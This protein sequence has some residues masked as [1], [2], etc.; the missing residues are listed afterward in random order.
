MGLFVLFGGVIC[1]VNAVM[2]NT[3]SALGEGGPL[4]ILGTFA[5]ITTL[6]GIKFAVLAVGEGLPPVL[7]VLIHQIVV[8]T[9]AIGFSLNQL[10]FVDASIDKLLFRQVFL[11]Y[12]VLLLHIQSVQTLG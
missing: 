8:L 11:E 7:I 3:V 9:L 12:V 6:A 4:G 1:F 10:G 5:E 2:K